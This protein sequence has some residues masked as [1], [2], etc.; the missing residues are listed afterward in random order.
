MQARITLVSTSPF[1][2][3]SL[4]RHEPFCFAPG[5]SQPTM[6]ESHGGVG[7]WHVDAALLLSCL[8]D[9]TRLQVIEELA[10]G[11]LNVA[12]LCR[13]IGKLQPAVSYHLAILRRIGIVTSRRQGKAVFYA[14]AF[15]PEGAV[16]KVDHRRVS[17]SLNVATT[18][19]PGRPD[20]ENPA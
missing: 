18:P 9:A 8:A 2:E 4:W 13:R 17:V 14:L 7:A 5:M 19:D 10:G 11:E 1:I 15:T 3:I 12:D 6:D 16:V 20:D